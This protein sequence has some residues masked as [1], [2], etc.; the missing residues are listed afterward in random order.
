MSFAHLAVLVLLGLTRPLMTARLKVVKPHSQVRGYYKDGEAPTP[1]Q[2]DEAKSAT[3]EGDKAMSEIVRHW[4]DFQRAAPL[5]DGKLT[6]DTVDK[7]M[8]KYSAMAEDF[9]DYSSHGIFQKFYELLFQ[10]E[11]PEGLDFVEFA[12]RW[13]ALH[14][15]D[16]IWTISKSPAKY[17]WFKYLEHDIPE[18]AP[19]LPSEPSADNPRYLKFATTTL[20]AD[21]PREEA[22][23]ARVA[24]GHA[25]RSFVCSVQ[26]DLPK[27]TA[28]DK[29][30][31]ACGKLWCGDFGASA[32]KASCEAAE[33]NKNYPWH[34]LIPEP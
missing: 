32:S 19:T 4:T 28:R 18:D 26:T 14:K 23:P 25:W 29:D 22:R 9:Y 2:I 24:C 16:A 6:K 7:Y 13:I 34:T 20:T 11:A 21:S 30:C 8:D 33:L 31:R 3:S 17:I 12:K 10:P 15:G 27:S 1:E 5:K